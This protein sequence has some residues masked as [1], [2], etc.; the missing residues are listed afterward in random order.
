MIR[1]GNRHDWSSRDHRDFK[2]LRAVVF[3]LAI[4]WLLVVAL[5]FG[6]TGVAH[7]EPLAVIHVKS[8]T[9]CTAGSDR[10]SAGCAASK[11]D[12]PKADDLVAPCPDANSCWPASGALPLKRFSDVAPTEFVDGCNNPATA[13]GTQLPIPW[14]AA[15]DPCKIWKIWP[16][17]TFAAANT[18]GTFKLSWVAPTQNTD[19]SALTDLAGFWIY[20][21]AN[22]SALGKL[23]QIK[24]AAT[25]STEL[26][27]YGPGSYQF[28]MSAYNAAGTESALTQAVPITVVTAPKVPG[29]P[30]SLSIVEVKLSQ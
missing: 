20:S 11:L 13:R 17:S 1:Q 30:V 28:A 24:S 25:T 18:T 6:S 4:F 2:G 26:S 3:A 15:A 21:A 23:V 16:A 29:A 8:T 7:S 9:A 19:G 10:S 27:G 14:S 12:I 5:S 22:G